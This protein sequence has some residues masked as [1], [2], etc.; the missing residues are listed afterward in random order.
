METVLAKIVADKA[1]WVEARKAQQPLA[2]FQND[3]VPSTRRFYDALR[4]ARTVFILECK[5][6]SPSKGVIRSDFD[7]A[8]IAGVYKHHAS[9]ISVLT[10]E[11]YFQG[12]FDFLPIVSAIAPQPVLCKDFII[13][14]YQIYL[15]RFYQADACLLML[16]VLDDDQ[17]RQLA[18][19]AHS[20]GM[21]VL[22]EVSNEEE[23][24]RA[25][26]LE[27]KVVG[28]N[29][30]DLRDLSID[31][32]RT[33]ELAPRLG[34][35]VTV[36][37]ESGIH[38]YGQVR[39]LSRFANGFLIGSALMEHDDLETAVRQVLLGENKV[40]GLTRPDD[41]QSALQAGAVFGGLIFVST[42][43]RAVTDEQ[44]RAVIDAAP[45]R[46]V[47]VFRD[48]PV[49]DVA[50]KA[51][52][53]SLAAIQL[54][55]DEDQTYISALRASLPETTAIWKA[56][57]VSHVLPPRNLQYVDRYVLDNGQG[58]SGQRFDWSLLEGQTLDNVMLAGGLGAD[59]CVQAA[60]LGCAGLDF[61]SGV[62]RAPGIKDSDK[63]AAVFRT[64]RAY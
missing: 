54:H 36:I 11:K 47:G 2:S 18:A 48:A 19:V 46:Y 39:E 5:K 53:F 49:E 27:A 34:H 17:Y 13:D 30:R 3:V 25:L 12:S 8:R 7:P 32:N 38:T 15:A 9:A 64:L 24:E 35:G 33:R 56:Q 26:R 29:N 58:G 55:G 16:S 40:C 41:A 51:N 10:D 50:A 62:E 20:L 37:S 57:S 28:I 60:Q 31:L 52:A 1:L 42:S 43:P 22:T 44:A 59:N 23:L 4:G 14:P 45:L 6:A 61:N 21:G 63:L